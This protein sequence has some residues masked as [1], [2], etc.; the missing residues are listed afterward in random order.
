MNKLEEILNEYQNKKLSFEGS[1][2]LE[3]LK[4]IN[5][6]I[7]DTNL[8]NQI[9]IDIN[10]NTVGFKIHGRKLI[11]KYLDILLE[12]EGHLL[13]N[14][15]SNLQDK[16]VIDFILNQ[17]KRN[18]YNIEP[19]NVWQLKNI[20]KK[21]KSSSVGIYDCLKL[22]SYIYESKSLYGFDMIEKIK[23]ESYNL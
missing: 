11:R 3:H 23:S 16:E 20:I 1:M 19:N 9:N 17:G 13:K 6:F 8:E 22:I 7:K 4:E 10:G 21:F 14:K 12:L 18:I 2:L 15:I 5:K